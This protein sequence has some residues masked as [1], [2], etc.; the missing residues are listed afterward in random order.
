VIVGTSTL[1]DLTHRAVK[2]ASVEAEPE[3]LGGPG[4]RAAAINRD[5]V[6]AGTATRPDGTRRAVRWDPEGRPAP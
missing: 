3:D 2:W 6:V 5:G 1:D 4:A